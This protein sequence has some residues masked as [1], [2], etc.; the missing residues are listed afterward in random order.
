MNTREGHLSK[1]RSGAYVLEKTHLIGSDYLWKVIIHCKRILEFIN[2]LSD[3]P[4]TVR[5]LATNLSYV[6]ALNL[7]LPET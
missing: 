7:C 3:V 5:I 2:V 4:C 6:P 1:R